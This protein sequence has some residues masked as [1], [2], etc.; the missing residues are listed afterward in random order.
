MRFPT[1]DL[2]TLLV[3]KSV[4]VV[5]SEP[6][7]WRVTM[8]FKPWSGVTFDLHP[9]LGHERIDQPLVQQATPVRGVQPLITQP[10]R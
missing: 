7:G 6:G 10:L 1:T 8:V 4:E 3:T 2:Q 5:N 9:E